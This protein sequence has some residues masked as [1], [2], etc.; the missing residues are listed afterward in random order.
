MVKGLLPPY[1]LR[2]ADCGL[3]K[4]PSFF[5][6]QDAILSCCVDFFIYESLQISEVFQPDDFQAP[7]TNAEFLLHG[8]QDAHVA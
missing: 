5:N 3:I 1:K 8:N 7:E 2:I 6:R 4:T